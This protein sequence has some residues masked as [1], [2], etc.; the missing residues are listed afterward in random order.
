MRGEASNVSKTD[1]SCDNEISRG[2]R[3]EG[4][5]V[6]LISSSQ[7]SSTATCVTEGS[8]ASCEVFEEDAES[9][10]AVGSKDEPVRAVELLE[11]LRGPDG[12]VV[13]LVEV[14]SSCG[15][16]SRLRRA[17]RCAR[18]MARCFK[19]RNRLTPLTAFDRSATTFSTEKTCLSEST[20][21][22]VSAILPWR[23]ESMD[24]KD[25]GAEV[26]MGTCCVI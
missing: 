20:R 24:S 3:S 1:N 15:W 4:K 6:D 10:L 14:V 26:L 12:G 21:L 8:N 13:V 25:S 11:A 22:G 2:E 18:W 5:M 19:K 23:S 17:V 9:F 16:G 7:S